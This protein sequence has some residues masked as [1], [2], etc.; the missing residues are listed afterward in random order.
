MSE[1]QLIKTPGVFGDNGNFVLELELGRGGMGGVYMGR[2]KMLDRPVAVKVM[3]KEYGNDTEF[4]EKFKR[5]AQAAARLI[6]PNIAQVYSYGISDGMPYIAMELVAGGSLYQLMQNTP[7]KTDVPRVLKICEQVAQALR[8]ASDQGLVHGDVK[9]ENILLDANG[10]AKLVD[11]GLAGMQKDTDEIWGTPYYIA[12]EKVRKLHVD[13]R[14]DM[15]S[16]GATL[17]H[18][19]TGFAPF[20]GA[21]ANEVVRKRFEG[22]PKKPSV[23]RPSLSPMIDKLVLKMIAMEPKDRYPTFEALLEAFKKVM[24]TGINLTQAVQPVPATTN[25]KKILIKKGT[26]HA[27][28]SN[29]T[30]PI[31]SGT[32]RLTQPIRTTQSIRLTQGIRTTQPIA[33]G[34]AAT[35]RK[36]QPLRMTQSIRATQHIQEA[37]SQKNSG[38]VAGK[39][40]IGCGV[41][42]LVVAL[43]GGG[44]AWYCYATAKEQYEQH[45]TYITRSYTDIRTSLES[46][47]TAATDLSQRTETEIAECEKSCDT[48]TKSLEKILAKNYPNLAKTLKPTESVELSL[49]R[50][51]ASGQIKDE[52]LV[53]RP[54]RQ[55]KDEELDSASPLAKQ[56]Q[57]EK[58]KWEAEEAKRIEGEIA[59]L[60]ASR[61]AEKSSSENQE[62]VPVEI[63]DSVKSIN[64]IW[65][66]IYKGRAAALRLKDSVST[67]IADTE[68]EIAKAATILN[69]ISNGVVDLDSLD[70]QVKEAADLT[71]GFKDR[72]E[73]LKISKDMNA[74]ADAKRAVAVKKG[75]TS[76]VEKT[77]AKIAQIE[78][79]RQR[80]LE[81]Q[82]AEEERKQREEEEARQKAELVQSE[83]ASAQTKFDELAA[84]RRFVQLDWS[85]CER[86]FRYLKDSMKTPEG[87][88]AVDQQMMKVQAMQSVQEILIKHMPKYTFVSGK[89]KKHSV[90]EINDREIIVA[91]PDGRQSQRI[92]WMKFC[93]DYMANLN[94]VLQKFI[95]KNRT[96][97]KHLNLREWAKAMLGISLTMKYVFEGEPTAFEYGRNRALEAVRA[98]PDY[99]P[100]AKEWLPDI[101]FEEDVTGGSG[102]K[103]E[104][105]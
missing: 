6:H 59:A 53:P 71:T 54:F 61:D 64:K 57:E 33:A 88:V 84:N 68:S 14:A 81:E 21:D 3:L 72:F 19:L 2:D 89:L 4:V 23:F 82:K 31:G 83:I 20:E 36:T 37:A 80:E 5:E 62:E 87:Q 101:A 47:R 38:S 74:V 55:P 104:G 1:E 105:E 93:R 48:A 86:D 13:Y 16:L 42:A 78:A 58:K 40:A 35:P 79:K 94:E 70:N 29:R 8:C 34:S 30:Q 56:Y 92:T 15:F 66:D 51:K 24:T 27:A 32:T 46:I 10:N 91:S 103:T 17:Y 65:A 7:G 76:L 102:A 75:E 95:V 12:P 63:K 90:R 45:K 11:F 97:D 52:K 18:A 43:V 99:L 39:V 28:A 25:G 26:S 73:Q 22:A 85:G 69:T 67:L 41:I 60:Q 49:A 77:A 96:G 98:F 9:P 100:L 44:L 50:Q